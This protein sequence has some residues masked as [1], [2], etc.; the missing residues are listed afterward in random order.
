MNL[1]KSWN[2]WGLRWIKI[3]TQMEHD[4]CIEFRRTLKGS[5]NLILS[6]SWYLGNYTFTKK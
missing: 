2:Q 5:T 1:S 6:G 3:L 4:F